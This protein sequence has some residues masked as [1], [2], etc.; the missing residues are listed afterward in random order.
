[1]SSI[2]R[3]LKRRYQRRKHDWMAQMTRTAVKRPSSYTAPKVET[4]TG[5]IQTVTPNLAGMPRQ[6]KV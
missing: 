1:M 6:R 5:R 3:T 2:V 4:K